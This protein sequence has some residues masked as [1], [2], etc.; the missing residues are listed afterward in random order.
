MVN[1]FKKNTCSICGKEYE[2][3]S[4]TLDDNHLSIMIELEIRERFYNAEL[5]LGL[6]EYCRNELIEK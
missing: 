4:L 2:T 1:R 6:C 5:N 3:Y